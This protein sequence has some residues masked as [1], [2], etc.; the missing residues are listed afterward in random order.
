M[1]VKAG[2]TNVS[3]YYYIVQDAS[4]TSPVVLHHMQDKAQ[5]ELI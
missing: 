3:V 5:Q 2:S 1:I 4:G